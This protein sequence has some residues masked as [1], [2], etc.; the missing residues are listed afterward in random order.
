MIQQN[1]LQHYI[2]FPHSHPILVD[3][4]QISEHKNS[5]IMLPALGVPIQKYEKLI[6]SLIQQ[7]FNVIAADY[8]GCG[9]NTP[10]V[11]SD[12]DFGY[13]DLLAYFIPQLVKIAKDLSKKTP[14]LFEHSL[15]G[16]L[17]T[18]FAQH[19]TIH[20]IGIA[21]GNI[22]L[23]YWNMSGKFNILKAATIFNFMILKDG[24]L[25]GD[26]VGFGKK[27][28]KTLMRDWS[29]VIFTGHY[30]HIISEENLS[31]QPA[32]FIQFVQDNFAPMRSTLAL[33][34][35]FKDAQVKQLDLT[36]SLKGNQHSV[37]LK[38]PEKVVKLVK[39][40]LQV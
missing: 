1:L 24:Y 30:R 14:V 40:F 13:A 25:A 4:Y 38:Q 10:Q 2:Q 22:G 34:R 26:K 33:S 15:G 27:E 6:Q 19:H 12:F 20:V 28:A 36:T 3:V 16:H 37:W 39:D 29:K 21:T 8:P 31:Q 23:K 7:G 11:S 9:R 35:Y 5:I 32:L 17:A 18:L